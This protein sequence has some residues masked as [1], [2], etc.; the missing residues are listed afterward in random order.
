MLIARVPIYSEAG[1]PISP[2]YKDIYWSIGDSVGSF[3]SSIDP[4]T[5]EFVQ[6]DGDELSYVHNHFQN[7]P[8]NMSK[9][10]NVW[11]EPWAR[12]IAENL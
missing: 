9:T 1:N 2:W 11:H 7:V 10:V 4:S 8:T 12:F 3:V 6:A 5:I